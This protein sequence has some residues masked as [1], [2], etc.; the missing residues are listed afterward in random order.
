ME[1]WGEHCVCFKLRLVCLT[2][3]GIN[4]VNAE[5]EENTNV[6]IKSFHN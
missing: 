3:E 1:N 5:K 4:E 2:L 6:R